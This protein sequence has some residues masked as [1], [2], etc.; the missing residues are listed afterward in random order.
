MDSILS[1]RPERLKVT[2]DCSPAFGTV[3]DNAHEEIIISFGFSG[4]TITSTI[5]MT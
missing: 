4:L 3:G 1:I 5:S 2:S